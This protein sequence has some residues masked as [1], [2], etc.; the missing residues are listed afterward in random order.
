MVNVSHY[1]NNWR[2]R[3][4]VLLGILLLLYRSL[5]IGSDKFHC[6]PKLLGNQYHG[7]S[8]KTLID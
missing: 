3:L 2:S 7:L 8:I 5:N 6:K 4:E 1:C